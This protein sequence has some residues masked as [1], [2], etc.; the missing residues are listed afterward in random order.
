MKEKSTVFLL[1]VEE[2]IVGE[3]S[4]KSVHYEVVRASGVPEAGKCG[5][6]VTIR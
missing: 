5:G 6:N 1:R 4:E 3:S 2:I